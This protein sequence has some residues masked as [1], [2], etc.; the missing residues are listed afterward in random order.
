MVLFY[1]VID[2]LEVFV[3]VGLWLLVWLWF[4]L[5][6]DVV[7][8]GFG[9]CA[10]AFKIVCVYSSK[11]LFDY[12]LMFWFWMF[13]LRF[14]LNVLWL[15]NS[16]AICLA[17]MCLL[18]MFAG[19]FLLWFNLVCLVRFG[20]CCWFCNCCL[21]FVLLWA[22]CWILLRC[23]VSICWLV[24]FAVSSQSCVVCLLICCGFYLIWF[25]LKVV[26]LVVYVWR[27]LLRC[28]CCLFCCLFCFV[29]C[30]LLCLYAFVVERLWLL[31]LVLFNCFVLHVLWVVGL[32]VL[33]CLTCVFDCFVCLLV[34]CL[35]VVIVLKLVFY[36][37]FV[38]YFVFVIVYMLVR[39]F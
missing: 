30:N 7:L 34:V 31:L 26:C 8:V 20:V 11:L 36:F 21:W 39:F 24:S 10:V 1:C 29:G 25:V 38:F 22:G 14:E 23:L 35:C 12:W 33:C 32:F 17:F 9:G 28:F 6:V 2:C 15:Y 5:V 37:D 16:V 4:C 18:G 3:Y 13:T 19:V 27:C